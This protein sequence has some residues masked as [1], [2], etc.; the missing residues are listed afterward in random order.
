MVSHPQGLL[1]LSPGPIQA[2]PH[3][4]LLKIAWRRK[5]VLAAG[6]VVGL[7][8]GGLYCQL[9]AP[10]YQSTAQVV[11]IKKR[12]EAVTG[13]ETRGSPED[14]V[15]THQAL[16]RSPLIVERAIHKQQLQTLRSFAGQ[17]DV[18]EAIIKALG[19]TR[20]RAQSGGEGNILQL[21]LRAGS[22]A[23]CTTTLTAILDSYK[24]FLGETY[25][26]TSAGTW[27]L[28]TQ[29]RDELRKELSQKESV[30]AEFREKTPLLGKAREGLEIHLKRLDGIQTKRSALLLRRVE[31]QAQLEAIAA[32]RKN[33]HTQ[34]ALLALVSEFPSRGEGGDSR[35][36]KPQALQDQLVPLLLEEQKL[37]QSYGPNHPDLQAVR[38]RIA[39]TR[40]FFTRPSPAWEVAT[41]QGGEDPA[42]AAR[43]TLELHVQYLVQ[44]LSELQI[45]EKLLDNLFEGEEETAKQLRAHES[46]DEMLRSDITR[47]QQLYDGLIKRVQDIGLAKDAGGYD[48]QTIAPPS[49][50]K[51]VAPRPVLILPVALFLGFLVG[52]GLA[53]VLAAA[54]WRFQSP[55]DV[56]LQLGLPLLG[57]VPLFKTTKQTLPFTVPGQRVLDPLLCTHYRSRSAEAEAFRSVRTALYF[58]TLFQ[59]RQ[60]IQIASPN[61]LDGKSTLAANLAISI[62]QSGKRV[63]LVDADLRR[64][65][66]HKFFSLSHAVGLAS[67]LAGVARVEEAVQPSG[68]AGLS[69]VPCGPTP[70]NPAELL[71]SSAFTD[72]LTWLRQQC[73]FVLIDTPAL[74]GVTDASVVASRVDGVVLVLR[75]GKD[76]RAAGEAAKD[77]LA[78]VGATLLGV[79]ANGTSQQ[80]G[81]SDF[82]RNCYQDRAPEP[83]GVSMSGEGHGGLPHNAQE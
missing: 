37:L 44:K 53:Y 31:L 36:D 78:T 12:P 38:K 26:T 65:R 67:V 72:L 62:A 64:P 73:D 49:V 1:P 6:A 59:G 70:P 45:S 83:L 55:E 24:D 42:P 76:G 58:S 18:T 35:R 10:V 81:D 28:I 66:L 16:I 22:A 60:I 40:A 69:V 17:Q 19:V 3:P 21:S 33:G 30:Y 75:L 63:I 15:A 39:A 8:L 61:V 51:Q 46:R 9:S 80:A 25:Q 48:P 32:A 68:I 13:V 71:T 43:D 47:T 74:L 27:K 23:D 4:V 29:A 7:V 56:R 50:G 82:A 5:W 34:Q 79:V 11:V 41:T 54:D 52:L 77:I 14:E 57:W 2:P 20:N